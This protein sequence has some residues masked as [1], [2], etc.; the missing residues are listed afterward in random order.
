MCAKNRQTKRFFAYKLVLPNCAFHTV[1]INIIGPMKRSNKSS[2][3]RYIIST[4]DHFTKWVEAEAIS[5][6]SAKET[7]RFILSNVIERHGC[8]QTLKTDN[9][10]NLTFKVVSQINSSLCV[11]HN[12]STP[13]YPETNGSIERVNGT[14]K[15]ILRQLLKQDFMLMGIFLSPCL[16]LPIDLQ[17]IA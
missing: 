10:S 12:F 14:L 8:P 17:Y 11:S 15:P 1:S 13:Y 4:V 16:S 7:A 2:N 3:N 9:D 6:L 5:I